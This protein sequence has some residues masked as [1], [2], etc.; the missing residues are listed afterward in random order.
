MAYGKPKYKGMGAVASGTTT[1]SPA[2]PTGIENGDILILCI[3]HKSAPG[4]WGSALPSPLSSFT[5]LNSDYKLRDGLGTDGTDD[6][7]MVETAMWYHIADGSET[8][9]IG[10]SILLSTSCQAVIMV[11]SKPP[12]TEWILVKAGAGA[13]VTTIQVIDFPP[14]PPY[15][16]YTHFSTTIAANDNAD[17]PPTS[18]FTLYTNDLV[19]ALSGIN[20]NTF[21]FSSPT[22]TQTS[23]TTVSEGIIVQDTTTNGNDQMMVISHH[24]VTSGTENSNSLTYSLVPNANCTTYTPSGTI[25]IGI[26][27]VRPWKRLTR[28]SGASW[29][30]SD[31]DHRFSSAWRQLDN[32]TGTGK[33]LERKT[34]S[35][36]EGVSTFNLS[37]NENT[38]TFAYNGAPQTKTI[39]SG[40]QIDSSS[41]DTWLTVSPEI[42]H[43]N[44]TL[45]VT[46]AEQVG[47]MPA[48]DGDVSLKIDGTEYA[49]FHV[50]QAAGPTPDITL[51]NY[52]LQWYNDGTPYTT[53]VVEV[54][55]NCDWHIDETIIP[56]WVTA[57]TYIGTT[58]ITNISITV[59]VGIGEA[60]FAELNFYSDVDST[61]RAAFSVGQTAD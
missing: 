58:G 54:T 59:D 29:V 10:I 24:R 26:L 37:V 1:C 42:I 9:T 52:S 14:I 6:Q 21:S 16:V 46:V 25:I 15:N 33:L 53:S 61:L 45:T 4:F 3:V 51:D 18:N 56:A 22:L 17:S 5:P 39:T 27:R 34:A 31:M 11:F 38:L 50:D 55:A 60:R 2:Y 48:R 12:D 44:D 43:G 30:W 19:I 36:F 7:G 23:S 40:H 8:G 49:T 13:D 32:G 57:N 35:V 47:G 28:K 20:S 41:S